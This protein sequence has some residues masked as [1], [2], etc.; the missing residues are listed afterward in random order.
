MMATNCIER[1]DNAIT[2]ELDEGSY[3]VIIDSSDDAPG[4]YRLVVDSH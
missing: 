3:F 2:R 4:E 1:A